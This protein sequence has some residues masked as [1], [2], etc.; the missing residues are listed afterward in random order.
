M[1]VTS[2][3]GGHYKVNMKG[4]VRIFWGI[5]GFAGFGGVREGSWACLLRL[6]R[7][8]QTS[9]LRNI[10]WILHHIKV[11][12]ILCGVFHKTQE[13]LHSLRCLWGS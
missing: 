2:G 4:C 5:M 11:P 10:L 6:V 1:S 12:A 13:C 8:S 3:F 7:D 9:G